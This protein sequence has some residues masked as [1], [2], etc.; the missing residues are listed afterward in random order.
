MMFTQKLGMRIMQKI[1]K[2]ITAY[3]YASGVLKQ[4]MV[5]ICEYGAELLLAG[6][7]N[8]MMIL[9]TGMLIHQIIYGIFFLM[10]M[11]PTRAFV[12]G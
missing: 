4:D 9:L 11:I 3:F 7:I 6:V 10:I 5:E 8:V 12:G 1:A 2:N